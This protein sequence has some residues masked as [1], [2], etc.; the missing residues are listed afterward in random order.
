M[1]YCKHCGMNSSTADKCE[2]CGRRLSESTPQPV[3]Q[4]EVHD[5]VSTA[6]PIEE[7]DEEERIGRRNYL[8]FASIVMVLAA[9]PLV[10]K[11]TLYVY[12][13]PLALFSM[14]AMLCYQRIIA[15]WE[16]DWVLVGI[17]LLAILFVP[18]F[19]VLLGYIGYSLIYKNLDPAVVWLLGTYV[20]ATDGLLG[21]AILNMPKVVPFYTTTQVFGLEKLGY[22]ALV[23]GWICGS[24]WRPVR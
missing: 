15:P 8:I 1:G 4:P 20:V 10:W 18:G 14:G 21:V 6:S 19:F 16:S 2:W 11:Y 24:S 9:C 23:F 3:G 17:L 12:V 7:L 13:I 5:G 22:L